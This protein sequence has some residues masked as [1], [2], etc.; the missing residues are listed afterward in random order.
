MHVEKF[1]SAADLEA[2]ERAVQGAEAHTSGEIV[3]YAVSHSDHYEAALWKGATL[4]AFLAVAAA[5]ASRILGDAWGGPSLPWIV[6][7]SLAGGALG[8]LAAALI[9]PLKLA[10]AGRA[11]VDHRV[12]ERAAAAFV[13]AEVFA[14]RERTGVLVFLS[15]Y[16]RRVVVMGDKGISAHV[17]QEEWDGLVAGIVTG[18]RAGRPGH[19]LAEAIARCGELLQ[20]H[21]VAARA[22]D[23]DEL[24]DRLRMREE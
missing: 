4:G 9:R 24:P 21:G 15:L 20:R 13:E 19:A 2:V 23:T 10:L 5:A 16:E 6:I 17:R 3:P 12:Q 14:T 18:M 7:P 22:D 8:Y 11:T 1:F